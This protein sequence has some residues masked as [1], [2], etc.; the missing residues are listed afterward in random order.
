MCMGPELALA[1]AV[2]S[3][4]AGSKMKHDQRE[5]SLSNQRDLTRDEIAR[6]DRL[7]TEAQDS[8]TATLNKFGKANTEADIEQQE[9]RLGTL[10]K[11]NMTDPTVSTVNPNIRTSAPQVVMD[12]ESMM[13]TAAAN[14]VNRDL[15]NQAAV[16]AFGSALQDL[17]PDLVKSAADT[18]M[19]SNLLRGSRGVY[20]MEMEEEKRNA[21]SPMGD[22]LMNLGSLGTGLSLRDRT[23]QS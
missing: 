2:G 10:L 16:S 19:I 21:F 23:V 8:Q 15:E 5:K 20:G 11:Q 6:S 18:A 13:R 22:L 14:R 4:I 12:T 3:T 7:T 17:Q 9:R 1:I